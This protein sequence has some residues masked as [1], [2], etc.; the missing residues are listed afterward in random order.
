MTSTARLV[1]TCGPC[2]SKNT[3]EAIVDTAEKVDQMTPQLVNAGKIRLHNQT[4]S[5][6]QHFENLH[7]QYADALHRLRSHVDD[8]ID[9]HEFVRASENAMRR[10]TNRCED[11]IANSYPQ[12]MVDNTSQIA[13]LGNRV[14]MAAQ[15]EA[16]NSEEPAYCDRVNSAANQVR[17]G[18]F[19]PTASA[20][21]PP[22][23]PASPDSSSAL[24]RRRRDCEHAV[25]LRTSLFSPA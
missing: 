21:T 7:R 14:L 5:A 13:R 18:E 2:K 8:A 15:N 25:L 10:Y 24:P 12:G 11:A 19:I 3:I 4:D 20:S 9:T 1:A 16:D 17:A 23:P 22:Q 6:E